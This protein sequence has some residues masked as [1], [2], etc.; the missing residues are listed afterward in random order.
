[1]RVGRRQACVELSN[2]PGTQLVALERATGEVMHVSAGQPLIVASKDILW[3]QGTA[4]SVVEL[5][6]IPG[7]E[8]EPDQVRRDT[9]RCRHALFKLLWALRLFGKAF[10]YRFASLISNKSTFFRC[11]RCSGLPV[12][13]AAAKEYGALA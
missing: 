2:L 6:K 10:G 12:S 7:F 9:A 3:F 8:L 5:R 4:A 13:L 1:M 11:W